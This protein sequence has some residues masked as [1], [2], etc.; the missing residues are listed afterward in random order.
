[1]KR[2]IAIGFALGLIFLS[3]GCRSY[4]YV[5]TDPGGSRHEIW[6]NTLLSDAKLQC[7]KVE[8][9]A[10]TL[11]LEGYSQEVN[12]EAVKAI[13]EGVTAAILKGIAPMP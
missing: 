7:L 6:I 11:S 13:T 1:M 8:S 4:Y 12:D 3:T 2:S 10:G 5:R 9:P